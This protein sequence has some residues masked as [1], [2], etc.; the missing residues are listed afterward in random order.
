MWWFLARTFCRVSSGWLVIKDPRKSK[1]PDFGVPSVNATDFVIEI[2][3]F[4]PK[5]NAV[6]DL[7][8]SFSP[9]EGLC[10]SVF[11]PPGLKAGKSFL[12]VS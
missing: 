4:A 10:R 12:H 6:N 9:A 5:G 7:S 3:A 1:L 11:A 2:R 8:S